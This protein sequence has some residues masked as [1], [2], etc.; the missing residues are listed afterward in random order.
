MNRYWPVAAIAVAVLV[1]GVGCLVAADKTDIAGKYTCEGTNPQGQ[2]YKGTVEITKVGDTYKLVWAIGNA[3]TWDGVG[4]LEGDVLAVSFASGV[5]V[6]KVEKG[7]MTGK[8]TVKEANG[9][10]FSET[11][12]K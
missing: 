6:Y 4:I 8:W 5:V 11:L 1:V 12:T 3:E 10:V 7:K 2:T 9:K